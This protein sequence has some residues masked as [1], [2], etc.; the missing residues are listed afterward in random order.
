MK[1]KILFISIF[2]I[3]F[4]SSCKK[5][6]DI[7]EST[8]THLN[9]QSN[10]LG[11]NLIRRQS[12][13]G[14]S[15]IT[16]WLLN[17]MDSLTPGKNIFIRNILRDMQGD[18][19]YSESLNDN[20]NLIIVPL[21]TDYFSK[22]IVSEKKPLQFLLLVEGEKGEIR[23]SDIAVFYPKDT[24]ISSLPEN[25]FQDFFQHES[26]SVN[27]TFGLISFNDL[28]EYEMDFD[29]GIKTQF[30]LWQGRALNIPI[31]ECLDY[32]LVT[33]WYNND[34][35]IYN[36]TWEYLWTSCESTGGGGGGAGNV[37]TTE[38]KGVTLSIDGRHNY[39]E[40]WDMAVLY[41][42]IGARNHDHP[43]QNYFTTIETPSGQ[44]DNSII[45]W[46]NQLQT[47][48][49][50]PYYAIFHTVTNQTHLEGCN[51]S[52]NYTIAKANYLGSLTYPRLNNNIEYHQKWGTWQASIEFH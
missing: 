19:M 48:P 27:G 44:D 40:G 18:K 28:K 15:D 51:T 23:R 30:R 25:S 52:S 16:S 34:G 42:L 14:Y 4:F 31:E 21:N 35:S 41:T 26:F 11:G 7:L 17:E 36:V 24:T 10:S 32:F 45:H 39:N 6:N 9:K 33:T 22:Q 46:T 38:T 8:P 49:A 47:Y 20:E 37:I 5:S 29:K 50:Y 3:V 1:T 2:G 13:I 43:D 12:T